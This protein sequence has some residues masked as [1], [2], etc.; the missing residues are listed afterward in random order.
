MLV[1]QLIVGASLS[2]TVTVKLHVSMFP[3]ASVTLKA[4]G[5]IPFLI[6]LFPFYVFLERALPAGY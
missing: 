1:E 3:R 5:V 2:L 6:V 4:L